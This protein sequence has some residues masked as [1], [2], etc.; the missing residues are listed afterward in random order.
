MNLCSQCGEPFQIGDW[1]ICADETGRHGHGRPGGNLSPL[2][3]SADQTTV[4]YEHPATGK[5]CYPGRN[6][7][8]MPER[9]VKRGFERREI[10]TLRGMDT[11]SKQHGVVNEK[12]HFNSGNSLD[13]G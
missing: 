11:F 13:G 4:V 9:Y 5:V 6:D 10:R 7:R 3:M 12:A 1:P 2:P 8:P